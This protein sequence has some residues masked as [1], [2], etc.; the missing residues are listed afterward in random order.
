MRRAIVVSARQFRSGEGA[1]QWHQKFDRKFYRGG[2]HRPIL[3]KLVKM[4][5][6]QGVP[7][8]NKKVSPAATMLEEYCDWERA[9]NRTAVR[10]K[11]V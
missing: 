6:A 10:G 2:L 7:D 5:H 9:K 3:R 1:V 4:K 11:K 8:V